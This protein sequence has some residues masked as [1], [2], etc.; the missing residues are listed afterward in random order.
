M[1]NLAIG[2]LVGAR[3]LA[4]V[5]VCAKNEGPDSPD[6]LFLVASQVVFIDLEDFVQ[7]LAS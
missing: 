7:P 3:V 5:R 4:L 2:R 1:V 6:C